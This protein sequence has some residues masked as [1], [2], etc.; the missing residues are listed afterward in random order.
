MIVR[1]LLALLFVPMVS[2]ASAVRCVDGTLREA[3]LRNSEMLHMTG[4]DLAGILTGSNFHCPTLKTAA[5]SSCWNFTGA[6]Q[7]VYSNSTLQVYNAFGV[8]LFIGTCA[9]AE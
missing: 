9:E 7:V 5:Y 2:H 6:I 1:V 3:I 8:P 4:F